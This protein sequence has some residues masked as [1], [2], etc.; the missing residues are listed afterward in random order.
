MCKKIAICKISWLIAHAL[1][2]VLWSQARTA[3]WFV[4]QQTWMLQSSFKQKWILREESWSGAMERPCKSIWILRPSSHRS[5][6]TRTGFVLQSFSIVILSLSISTIEGWVSNW[7][8]K[9]HYEGDS[10]DRDEECEA[11]EEWLHHLDGWK[12]SAGVSSDWRTGDSQP[13]G[14]RW[15]ICWDCPH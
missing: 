10:W 13:H 8:L 12:L 9:R 1:I 6:P 14:H 4:Q 11:Q 15:H 3:D 7:G 5:Y 2:A